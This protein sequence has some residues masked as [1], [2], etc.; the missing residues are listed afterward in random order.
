MNHQD[1][2]Q[3]W[4]SPDLEARITAWVLGEASPFEIA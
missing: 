3:P 1:P 4:I 2:L